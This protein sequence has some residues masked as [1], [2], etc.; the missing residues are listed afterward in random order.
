M[1][2]LQHPS[3]LSRFQG[4]RGSLQAQGQCAALDAGGIR[5][6]LA[7]LVLVLVLVLVQVP[8]D[9]PSFPLAGQVCGHGASVRLPTRAAAAGDL[10]EH[11]TRQWAATD[12][13]L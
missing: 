13:A 5:D 10:K 11:A 6:L 9:C 1:S 12:G 4:M 3:A 8:M 7:L 2:L